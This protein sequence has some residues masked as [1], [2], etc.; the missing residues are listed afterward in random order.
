[1]GF[2]V[3][4]LTSFIYRD[5]SILESTRKQV[6]GKAP[7]PSFKTGVVEKALEPIE[8][9][10]EKYIVFICSIDIELSYSITLKETLSAYI[11]LSQYRIIFSKLSFKL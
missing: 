8:N 9:G 7:N 5:H 10:L 4:I 2:Q 11:I 6:G 3:L 1:M